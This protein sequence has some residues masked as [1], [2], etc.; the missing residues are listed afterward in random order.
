MRRERNLAR[1]VTLN[2]RARNMLANARRRANYAG[3]EC[4]VTLAWV[5][6]RLEAGR[7]ARTGKRFVLEAGK[8][9]GRPHPFAPSLDR[10]DPAF[11]YTPDNTQVV[12]WQY[13]LAKGTFTDADV[14]RFARA[15]IDVAEGRLDPATGIYT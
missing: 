7:C 14:V 10:I 13:N 15:V 4:S 9:A 1:H 12:C 2:G 5:R 8:G 3:F 11:G 6:A